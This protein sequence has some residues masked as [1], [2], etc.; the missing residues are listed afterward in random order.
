MGALDPHQFEEQKSFAMNEQRDTLRALDASYSRLAAAEPEDQ[1]DSAVIELGQSSTS[2]SADPRGRG[3]PPGSRNKLPHFIRQKAS[4]A[5]APKPRAPKVTSSALLTVDVEAKPKRSKCPHGKTKQ[6]CA[7]CKPDVICE[8]NRHKQMCKHCG[9][10]WI[11]CSHGRL[12]VY[13]AECGGARSK[14]RASCHEQ[15]PNET[16]ILLSSGCASTE[17]L[18]VNVPE[19]DVHVHMAK[20]YTIALFALPGSSASMGT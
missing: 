19:K 11:Y 8:H 6:R 14:L 12:R 17:R 5:K 4:K 7:E 13:C 1:V 10:T 16:T 15:S 20:Q 9:G 2:V 3:R 18:R